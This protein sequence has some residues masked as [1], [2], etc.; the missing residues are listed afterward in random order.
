LCAIE[1]LLRAFVAVGGVLDELAYHPMAAPEPRPGRSERGIELEALLVQLARVR[2]AVVGSRE[3][4]GAQIQLV[5]AG[6]L[7]R[8]R[9]RH[10]GRRPGERQRQRFDD[11]LRDVVLQVKQIAERRLH[12]V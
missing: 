5:G 10:R 11:A 12:R 7:R 1:R 3:L 2:Q 8:I 9:R 4:V 6:M